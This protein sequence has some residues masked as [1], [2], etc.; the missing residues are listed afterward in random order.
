LPRLVHR[1]LSR[2][3]DSE[4]QQLREE[5]RARDARERRWM[6]VIAALLALVLLGQLLPWLSLLLPESY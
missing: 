1:A 5:L 2:E 3:G 6:M 4:V